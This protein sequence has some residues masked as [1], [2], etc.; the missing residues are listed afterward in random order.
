MHSGSSLGGHVRATAPP[1]PLRLS[2]STVNEVS[3]LIHPL[4]PAKNQEQRE[5]DRARNSRHC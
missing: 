2:L 5:I 4:H 3:I 1:G